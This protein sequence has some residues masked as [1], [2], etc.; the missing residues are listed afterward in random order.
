VGT[1]KSKCICFGTSC[2]G[3]IY[4]EQQPNTIALYRC[5]VP[6]T[7]HFISS[8]PTCEG[9]QVETLLGYALPG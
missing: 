2:D 5:L 8:N 6:T 9:Q 3:Y 7:D 4:T 1:R